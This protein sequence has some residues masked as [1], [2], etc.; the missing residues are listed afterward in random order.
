MQAHAAGVRRAGAEEAGG[1]CPRR[2]FANVSSWAAC[3]CASQGTEAT[4]A[5][6]GHSRRAPRRRALRAVDGLAPRV[7]L[8]LPPAAAVDLRTLERF[9]LDPQEHA[10]LSQSNPEELCCICLETLHCHAP[11]QLLRLPCGHVQHRDC[12]VRWLSSN[13]SCPICR[14]PI[15][16][17]VCEGVPPGA[18]VQRDEGASRWPLTGLAD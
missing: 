7:I 2:R 4:T 11:E 10:I 5:A 8:P 17:V 16:H 9:A 15:P 12:A 14:Q 1:R 18:V 6:A 13:N 3:F